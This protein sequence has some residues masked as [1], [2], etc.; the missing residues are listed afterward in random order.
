MID[1]FRRGASRVLSTTHESSIPSFLPRET[2][3]MDVC[4]VTVRLSA[5]LAVVITVCVVLSGRA[6]SLAE[7]SLLLALASVAG[8]SGFRYLRVRLR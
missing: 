3:A 4:D 6:T 7:G 1:R 5:V 8:R 2:C